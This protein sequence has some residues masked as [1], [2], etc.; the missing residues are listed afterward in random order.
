MILDS[1]SFRTILY[2]YQRIL[3]SAPVPL[4]SELGLTGLGLWG[5][6][7]WRQG[8]TI[9]KDM[10]TTIDVGC[11]QSPYIGRGSFAPEV[12]QLRHVSCDV[13]TR[14]QKV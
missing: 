1:F 2:I 9:T 5:Q 7:F 14:V 13:E 11:H 8:L 10:N 3:V 6:R 4:D 12:T